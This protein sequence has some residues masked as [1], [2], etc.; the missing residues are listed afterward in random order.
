MRVVLGKERFHLILTQR[1]IT[2]RN[3]AAEVHERA[4]L[5]LN[6]S[7]RRRGEARI[8]DAGELR[9]SA[10]VPIA[11]DRD[12]LNFGMA[13]LLLADR[14]ERLEGRDHGAAPLPAIPRQE[15]E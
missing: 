9:P 4:T 6:C 10:D 5:R 2:V 12:G 14:H 7:R 3:R 11:L 8:H 13:Q 15:P 1:F